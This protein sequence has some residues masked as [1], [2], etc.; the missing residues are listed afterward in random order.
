MISWP[1]IND[2]W[3]YL[4]WND[5]KKGRSEIITLWAKAHDELIDKFGDW[6]ICTNVL[7]VPLR[8]ILFPSWFVAYEISYLWL[9]KHFHHHWI[10]SSNY[11]VFHEFSYKF[12][13]YTVVSC[14]AHTITS[15]LFLLQNQSIWHNSWT[16]KF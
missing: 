8:M 15:F 7:I 5:T 2:S 1:R 3:A 10:L 12:L 11:V 13:W 16:F 9:G 14:S 6:K 4:L